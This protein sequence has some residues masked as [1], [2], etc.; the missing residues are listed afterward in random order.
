MITKLHY[1]GLYNF[2]G[3]L[4]KEEAYSIA[5]R[6]H[7]ATYAIAFCEIRPEQT[8][9]PKECKDVFY[10]GKS[11]GSDSIAN[12]FYDQKNKKNKKG[13]TYTLLKLRI[14]KHMQEL[15]KDEPSEEK[16][17]FFKEYYQPHLN[18]KK[19]FFISFCIPE[20]VNEDLKRSWIGAKEQ[21]L[22]LD[23][24]YRFGKPPLLNLESLDPEFKKKNN[25]ISNS[26]INSLINGNIDKFYA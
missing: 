19:Q 23:Y 18:R 20:N 22:I 5:D 7:A 25:S 6:L 3:W 13:R 8:M 21:E 26:Y 9:L 10:I 1:R 14:K 17:K 2:T 4:T 15:V 24:G 16:Y 12:L 11:G